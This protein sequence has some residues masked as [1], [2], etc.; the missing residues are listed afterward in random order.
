MSIKYLAD[1]GFGIEKG[2]QLLITVIIQANSA[3][4]SHASS[5]TLKSGSELNSTLF[6]SWFPCVGLLVPFAP[7]PLLC[8]TLGHFHYS[9]VTS[10]RS[11]EGKRNATRSIHFPHL[12]FLPV[13]GLD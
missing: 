5:L 3:I 13:E 8:L 12:L 1:T 10:T 9:L 4:T 11:R 2:L 6:Q 7:P